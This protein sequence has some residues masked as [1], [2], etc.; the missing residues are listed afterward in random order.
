M[1]TED[2]VRRV[3]LSLPAVAEKP[4][5]RLASFRVRSKLFLRV[6]ELPDTVFLRCAGIGERDELLLAEPGK[7]FITPHYEGYPGILLRLSQV[8]LDELTEL[9]TEAWRTCAPARLR[10]AYDTEHPSG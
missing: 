3:C 9:V 4:Y 10:T 6:H 7:F 1:V 5:N 8:D 2:D